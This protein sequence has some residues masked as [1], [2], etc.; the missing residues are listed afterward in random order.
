MRKKH[1]NVEHHKLV[2]MGSN[3]KYAIQRIQ[4]LN[5]QK[6]N[7]PSEK[8]IKEKYIDYVVRIGQAFAKFD[9]LERQFLRNEYFAPLPK[10]WWVPFYSRAT[11]Y[12]IRLNVARK[13][14][15]YISMV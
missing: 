1:R 8:D 10:G 11:Y 4:E 12:R 15:F 3:Y 2:A 7:S 13:F 9:H 14:L 5:Q 6:V